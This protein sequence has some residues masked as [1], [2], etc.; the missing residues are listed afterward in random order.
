MIYPGIRS[1]VGSALRTAHDR[2]TTV[3]GLKA[4]IAALFAAGEAGLD[5]SEIRPWTV[6]QDVAGTV[7][8]VVG[9]PVRRILDKSGR[10]RHATQSG[11]TAAP[12]LQLDSSGRYYLQCDGVDDG[13][14]CAV[15][16]WTP[17]MLIA[18]AIRA[19]TTASHLLFSN[20]SSGTMWAGVSQAGSSSAYL[21]TTLG[22]AGQK[23]YIDGVEVLPTTR[24]ALNTAIGSGVAHVEDVWPLPMAGFTAF[25]ISQYSGLFFPGRFYGAIATVY[26]DVATAS[27]V[28]KYLG[29]KAGLSL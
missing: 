16:G 26:S 9:Q 8:G 29:Q 28:R 3:R 12:T 18:A 20:A 19:D 15:S 14:G 2:V 13:F 7:A 24:G 1:E 10:G 17:S 23:L 25:N 21:D 6:W 22:N 27:L 4:Q 5:W 11:A